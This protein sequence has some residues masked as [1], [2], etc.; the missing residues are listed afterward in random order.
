MAR[1]VMG[2]TRGLEFWSELAHRRKR[3]VYT[4]QPRTRR[5]LGRE[6]LTEPTAARRT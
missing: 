4:G 3:T 5:A 2:L 6:T 1:F